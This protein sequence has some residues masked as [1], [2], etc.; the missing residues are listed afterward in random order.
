MIGRIQYTVTIADTPAR[1]PFSAADI[2]GLPN[3]FGDV[4]Q[5]G[6]TQD[7]LL[8]WGYLTLNPV[9]KD[10]RFMSVS[11]SGAA[12]ISWFSTLESF[13]LLV[14]RV[15]ENRNTGYANDY[16]VMNA[17]NDE[18]ARGTVIT[19]Y[20]DWEGF[21]SEFYSCVSNKRIDQKRFNSSMRWDFQFDLMKLANVQFPSTVPPFVLA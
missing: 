19:W 1:S 12:E 11:S 3:I 15:D 2:F 6:D 8:D 10:N 16:A 5:P 17:L 14:P 4:L 13:T 21:P 7:I 18:L 9:H 20:P